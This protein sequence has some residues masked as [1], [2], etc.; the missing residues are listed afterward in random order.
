MP[1]IP[2]SAR[3]ESA[4]FQSADSFANVKSR[5]KSK[6]LNL[7]Q[8]RGASKSELSFDSRAIPEA[9]VR[10]LIAKQV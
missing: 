8:K 3:L 4:P 1:L 2:A 7:G 5:Y 10:K 9:I 6:L